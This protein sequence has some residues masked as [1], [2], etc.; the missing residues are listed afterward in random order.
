MDLPA[1]IV[2][3]EG[4]TVSRLTERSNA[5]WIES[6]SSSG[7]RQ[8]GAIEDLRSVL[9]RG[10]RYGLAS[11]LG[12]RGAIEQVEDFAQDAVLRILAS[13]DTFRGESLFTTWAQKIAMRIAFSELRRKRWE[14]VSL[15]EL[16][17]DREGP[18]RRFDVPEPG[19][20]PAEKTAAITALETV[21]SIIDS[22]LTDLQRS[23]LTAVIVHGM[24]MEAVAEQLGTNRNALYKLLHDARKK[25]FR[26]VERR[27]I[28]IDDLIAHL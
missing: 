13:L 21:T 10:L 11:R 2:S 6:L 4:R 8:Q 5:E 25:V 19:A 14:N 18:A 22:S 15:D 26:E 23:A 16:L 9:I 17:D 7:R 12:R 1:Q 20:D 28:A 3:S 24:P 27:G